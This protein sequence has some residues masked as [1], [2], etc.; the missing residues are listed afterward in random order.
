[1]F[2]ILLAIILVLYFY[3]HF[4]KTRVIE[5]DQTVE[6]MKNIQYTINEKVYHLKKINPY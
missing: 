6:Q 4:K 1:M 3:L 2:K 5:I